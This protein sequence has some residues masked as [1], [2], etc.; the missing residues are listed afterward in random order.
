MGKRAEPLGEGRIVLYKSARKCC[1]VFPE[2]LDRLCK[3]LAERPVQGDYLIPSLLAQL[4]HVQV[5]LP[6]HIRGAPG[7]YSLHLGM[8][9]LNV[10]RQLSRCRRK[11]LTRVP[12]AGVDLARKLGYLLFETRHA[13]ASCFQEITQMG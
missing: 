10:S 1:Q 5:D 11:R 13:I 4:L 12:D 2:C 3:L 7:E 9:V 8:G 6:V